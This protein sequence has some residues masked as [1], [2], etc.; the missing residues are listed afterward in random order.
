MTTYC[1]RRLIFT[2]ICG[3]LFLGCSEDRTPR[4]APIDVK[5]YCG[6]CHG[7]AD[8]PAPSLG[9]HQAHRKNT[10]LSASTVSCETC[11][12]VPQQIEAI[13][14][15]DT[16]Y[17]AEVTFSGLATSNST[18]AKW[19]GNKCSVYCHGVTLSGGT[20]TTPEWSKV[21]LGQAACGSCHGL[22]PTE[23]HPKSSACASCHASVASV[24]KIL[25]PASH[26]NGVVER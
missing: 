5:T 10:N 11:H 6:D 3:C 4:S 25:K 18:Q 8:D 16:D 17:P 23:A 2:I 21:G 26:I 15:M 7:S 24:D 1:F 20:N 14:H 19:D 13:G 12:I 9:A 22:P